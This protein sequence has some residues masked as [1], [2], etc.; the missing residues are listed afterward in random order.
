LRSLL[1]DP[2][3]IERLGLAEIYLY[4]AARAHHLE[5]VVLPALEGG[6]VVVCDRFLDSTR[7][8]Q[9]Y[10]RGRPL[11]LI[12]AIHAHPPLDRTPERTLLLDVPAALGRARSR[13]RRLDE[14]GGYDGADPA[15]L[16]RVRSGFLAIAERDRE[17]VRVVDARGDA[18]AVHRAVLATLADLLP[19]LPP[20]P[21]AP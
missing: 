6:Q 7:C 17:R 10:G 3:N 1:K 13:G 9:G 11:E 21:E 15:F 20:A 12:E 5:S 8:Y 19:N 4:A 18:G 2:V 14:K 16:D